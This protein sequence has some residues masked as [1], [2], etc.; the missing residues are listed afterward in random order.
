MERATTTGIAVANHV[1]QANGL[2][3]WQLMPPPAPEPLARALE[4][5]VRA[6]RQ[7]IGR[8]ILGAARTIRGKR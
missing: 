5:G 6:F 4:I 8:A 1:L 2:E 3:P 7:T